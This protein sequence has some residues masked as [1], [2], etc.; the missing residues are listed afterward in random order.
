[1]ASKLIKKRLT[2][3]EIYQDLWQKIVDF[4]LY[5]GTRVTETELAEQYHTSR[6]PVREALKRLEVEGLVSI[7][8]K[9]GCFVRPVDMNLIADY[10]TAR[11]AIEAMAVELACDYMDDASIQSL[12]E[13]WNPKTY[14]HQGLSLH[15]VRE[16]EENFHISIAKGSANRVLLEYLQDIN[17]R[18]RPLRLMGFPD[19]KSI[20]DTFKEH[21]HICLQIKKRDKENARQAMVKHIRKSQ[22]IAKTVTVNQLQQYR[23]TVEM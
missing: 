1:M 10:Y 3:Q 16:R 6:T 17:S 9:Q 13:Q 22:A 19:E 20:V 12:I 15:Q 5:P 7:R 11:V 18:I 21:H 8:P 14:Q 4:V 2:T 23:K